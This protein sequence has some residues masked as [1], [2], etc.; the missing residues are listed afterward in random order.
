MLEEKYIN[1]TLFTVGKI[2]PTVL[3]KNM[4]KDKNCPS[5]G[6]QDL[7]AIFLCSKQPKKDLFKQ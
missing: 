4:Q 6:L 2:K 7:K 5:M 1:S 3:K